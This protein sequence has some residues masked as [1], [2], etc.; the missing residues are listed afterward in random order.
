MTGTRFQMVAMVVVVLIACQ[1]EAR[2]GAQAP[3]PTLIFPIRVHAR[4]SVEIDEWVSSQLEIVN[5]RFA[6]AGVQFEVVERFWLAAEYDE[7]TSLEEL[8]RMVRADADE[9]VAIDVFVV[10]SFV[11]LDDPDHEHVI[12]R[13]TTL[14]Q[15][16]EPD[17]PGFV[18]L[19]QVDVAVFAHEL[20]HYFGLPHTPRST[21]LMSV[22][23]VRDVALS[24]AQ[25]AALRTA[26]EVAAARRLP[27][28]L[29]DPFG[30]W[31][32]RMPGLP[33]AKTPQ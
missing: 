12:E 24:A 14:R 33:L 20:G 13:G 7:I 30:P 5:L 6:A 31:R 22:R 2:A 25:V 17:T 4:P 32:P 28:A 3:E 15:G 1:S 8:A 10:D 11:D 19:T 27:P 18:L 21:D 9:H 29:F 23:D 26:A 16:L